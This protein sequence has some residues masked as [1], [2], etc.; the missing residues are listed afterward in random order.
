M[1]TNVVSHRGQC[2]AGRCDTFFEI[3]LWA[4]EK[5]DGLRKYLTLEHGIPSHD[6]FGRLFGLI[7]P[8][9]FEAAF[10]SWVSQIVPVLGMDTVVAIDGK[11]R[12]RSSK[13]GETPLHW[14][15]AFAAGVGLVLGQRA[16]AEQSNEK[17]AIPSNARAASR[18][19]DLLPQPRISIALSYSVSFDSFGIHAIVLQRRPTESLRFE[20]RC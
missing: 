11:T 4:K 14:V 5:E 7:D 2:G 20:E 6:T 12:R 15:S 17:T 19:G 3:E 9:L 8:D 1:N 10:R 16:T 13:V 18:H